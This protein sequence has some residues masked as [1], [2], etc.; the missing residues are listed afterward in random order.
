M[1]NSWCEWNNCSRHFIAAISLIDN[2][3]THKAFD[4]FMK[5][6]KGVLTESFLEKIILENSI[7]NCT[8]NRAMKQYYLK[9][10]QLFEQHSALDYVI[11]LAKAAI[12]ILDKNDPQLVCN[13]VEY[14]ISKI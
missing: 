8:H 5:A 11:E 12:G 4:L 10:I 9:V 1:L 13:V 3:E 14:Y 2:G 7:N 6:G